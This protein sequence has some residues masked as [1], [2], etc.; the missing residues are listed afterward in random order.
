M[1]DLW[2]IGIGDSDGTQPEQCYAD[3]AS[4]EGKIENFYVAI[5]FDGTRL[6]AEERVSTLGVESPYEYLRIAG[7]RAAT[8][9]GKTGRVDGESGFVEVTLELKAGSLDELVVFGVGL[10]GGSFAKGGEAPNCFQIDVDVSV[11]F[12]EKSYGFGRAAAAEIKNDANGG[13]N[14][15]DDKGYDKASG[16][17]SHQQA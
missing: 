15:D 13:D 11:S 3:G 6:L 7:S 5:I 8:A 2:A 17:F 10:W 9:S 12:G 16:S 14:D 4:F 1:D